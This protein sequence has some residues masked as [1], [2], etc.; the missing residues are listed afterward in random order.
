M[1]LKELLPGVKG[2]ISELNIKGVT[3]N[4]KKVENGYVFVCI[5]GAGADGHDFYKSAL[6]SGA[7]V[8]I[9]QKDLKIKNQVIVE[10]TRRV[11]ADMCEKWFGSPAKKLNL[12]GV[13]GTNGKTSVTYI[14]KS[15]LEQ[16]GHKVGLIGTIQNLIGDTVVDSHNTTPEAYELNSLF[17]KMI[18]AGCDY[19]VMEVSSHALDQYRVSNLPFSVAIF[20]NLTQDHLDYHLTMENYL[21]AKKRLFSMCKI[22]VI[23]ADDEYAERLTEDLD[24]KVV[25][26]SVGNNGVYSARAIK[27]R[28]D[29][30][31]YELL[32]GGKLNHIRVSTGGAF[33]VYNS[34]LAG[35]AA[36]ET[37]ISIDDVKTALSKMHGVKGRAESVPTGRDFTVIID[38]AHTPDGLK[39]ILQT[40]KE[41]EKNRLIVLFGC[42]GDRDKTKRPVMGNIAVRNADYVIVTSD[43]PRTEEPSVI[44]ND[45]LEGTKGY[46]TPV[47]VIENRVE[48]IKYAIS[49]ACAGD[50]IVLAGKGHETYQIL[51]DKTI[52]LDERE[53]IGEALNQIGGDKK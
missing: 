9:T 10:N 5:K 43:N 36:L 17:D 44:I 51:K 33:T 48:A 29:S 38:Y 6:D 27:Y 13:T 12:I 3:C 31:E 35:V 45:I 20:T 50:I 15:I 22:A 7:A 47:K 28:P 40:F 23:N 30:V 8:I 24:C 18:S 52:H 21:A 37:G 41:C 19:C 2:D 25:T 14:L 39:N 46:A 53:I 49:T 4:S 11:Y 1:L 42:G 26:C 16:A 32:Y 34:M